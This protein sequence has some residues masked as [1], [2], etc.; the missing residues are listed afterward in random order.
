MKQL[1]LAGLLL[2]AVGTT[3]AQTSVNISG[4]DWQFFYAKDIHTADSLEATGFWRPDYNAAHWNQTP[5]PSNWAIL[6]YEEPVYRGFPD[7]KASEGF[8]IRKF[9]LPK[10][11]D[12]KRVLLH[13]GGV[14]NSAEVWLN[15]VYLG[16]HDSGYTSFTMNAT[17]AAKA[18]TINTLAV[19]VRQVYHGYKTDTYD[20]WTL[21]G[22]YR[23]VTLEAMPRRQWI[24]NV[25]AI[26]HFDKDYQNAELEV[27]TIIANGEKNTLPGNYPSPGKDYTLRVSLSD[28]EGKV[29]ATRDILVKGHIST[30]K[31][32][33]AVLPLT[34]PNKWTA[35]TP[36]LYRL[37]VAILN[38][39]GPGHS[40]V[41]KIG[42]REVSTRDGVLRINGQAVKLRGV[43]RHDEHPDVG[44]AVGPKHWLEDLQL[45]KDA[46]VNYVRACHYQHA[47]QFIEMCDS[48]GMYVGAEVSL[49]GAGTMMYDPSFVGPVMLRCQE[50]VE[51]DLNNPSIIYW[52]VGNEDPFTYMHLRAIRTVKGIDPTRP[53]LMPWNASEELPEE[54]DILAPHYWTSYEYDSIASQSKRPIVT[55]EYV[56]AYGLQRFGGL[57]DCFKALHKHPAGAGGAVW[58]W[59]DQGIKTPTKKDRKKYGSLAKDDDYLRL[60]AA[61]WD[62]VTDSY[63]KPTRDFWEVKAVYAPVFPDV[64]GVA[65]PDGAKSIRIPI[66]NDYDFIGTNNIS[67]SYRLLT[68]NRLLSSGVAS[69]DA[70]PHATADLTIDVSKVGRLREGQTCY[71]QLIF[72]RPDGSEIG[73]RSVELKPEKIATV[74]QKQ[75]DLAVVESADAI[76]VTAGKTI[77]RF[78]RATGLL[79][80]ITRNGKPAIEALRPTI[81]HALNDGDQIIKNRKFAAGIDPEKPKADVQSMSINQNNG[82]VTIRSA[83]AYTIDD[84]NC[85][86]ADYAQTIDETGRFTID[87]T[88][89]PE[90]QMNYLPIVGM[91]VKMTTENDLRQWLGLGPDD[92]YPNKKAGCILGVWD[93]SKLTGTRQARWLDLQSRQGVKTRI[94]ANGY[95]DR[96]KETSQEV[97]I[98]SQVLGR[99]EKGRLNDHNYQVLPNKSYKGCFTI[100]E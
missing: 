79:A 89:R 6:G 2:T 12:D 78:N 39:D 53:V 100:T 92:A 10:S 33:K 3:H 25:T 96:D 61:G 91:A 11:F 85:F 44:R 65:L 32:V 50:T 71:V 34:A 29:V 42:I 52:S 69:V 49:G 38:A 21:G 31:D 19:R 68:D 90:V 14:W 7:N 13:F 93:A 16:R 95:I 36:Y 81:W 99:S 15:G 67:I 20:D 4:Q 30:S 37:E 94:Q 35:E 26:T 88:I 23:D 57:E 41:E 63:R 75:Q 73:R 56:H 86:T 83:V 58:M 60:D 48:I 59:A 28:N 84:N 76:T 72:T 46:N 77:Y 54:V 51:R 98:L 24:D 87:Y 17:N 27:R 47:K 18:D 80:A 22:I 43:N 74:S 9:M 55:T 8:Y 70:A 40:K 1:I 62:G 66:R 5:V 64:D 97:R 45:M 82:K